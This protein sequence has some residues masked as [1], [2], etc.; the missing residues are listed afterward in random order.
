MGLIQPAL[1]P[2]DDDRVMMIL[3]DSGERSVHTAFSNDNGWTWSEAEPSDLPNPDAAIDAL[4]LHDGRI[5]LVYNHSESGRANLQLA[6]SADQGRTWRTGA[7]LEQGAHQEY[8]YP[9]LVEDARGRIHLTYTWQRERIKHVTFTLAW[10][11]HRSLA[12]HP[13][14]E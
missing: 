2:L 14:R 11:D 4:R 12:Q 7:I 8:S 3:R 10:L 9:N 1:V 13:P 6:I 5:L